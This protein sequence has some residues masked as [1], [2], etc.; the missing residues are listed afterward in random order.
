MIMAGQQALVRPAE[1]ISFLTGVLSYTLHG[2][3]TS[4]L[5]TCELG[6]PCVQRKLMQVSQI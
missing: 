3:V 5:L 1:I 4:Q 6:S 2:Q